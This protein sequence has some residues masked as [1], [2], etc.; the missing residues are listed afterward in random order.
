MVR[1]G[2]PSI[3]VIVPV[4][5]VEPYLRRCLNSILE[6]TH[7]DLEILIIDDGSTDGSGA[8]CDAYKNDGRV[9]VFHTEN[10]GLSA[11][12]NLG[13]DFVT[14]QYIGF[15]DSDDWIEPDMFEML[16]RKAIETGK[17]VIACGIFNEYDKGTIKTSYHY[18]AENA[19]L[20]LL[21][22]ELGNMVWNKLWRKSC[23]DRVRF[24]EGMLFEDTAIAYQIFADAEVATIPDCY[25]H[26]VHRK[27]SLSQA[28]HLKSIL[29]FWKVHRDR[30]SWCINMVTDTGKQGLRKS[31]AYVVSRAWVWHNS[32]S[33]QE[34]AEAYP[35]Y[36]E[37]QA[38]VLE[39]Y[40]PFG[41]RDWPLP[42]RIGVFL[43]RYRSRISFAS[44][45][46]LRQICFIIKQI[47]LSNKM[48]K[49]YYEA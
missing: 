31:C 6:Q 2:N 12:R 26:Y 41:D 13:L 4:Y 42:L 14:G 32:L 34:Q 16:Y 40:D 30:F 3:S 49:R 46:C 8:I 28:H 45:F 27:H 9:R 33:K 35:Y 47:K 37:M 22:N 17:D 23:F 1:D 24:P 15:V 20:A 39:H 11:A 48:E 44:V 36:K 25:Y 29:D 18:H 43:A 21:N 19:L 5:N 38:F 7:R 10:R